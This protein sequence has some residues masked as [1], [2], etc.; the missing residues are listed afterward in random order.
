ML[1]RAGKAW[2]RGAVA[3]SLTH[4]EGRTMKLPRRR[5][6][7][8]ATLTALSPLAVFTAGCGAEPFTLAARGPFPYRASV[9]PSLERVAIVVTITSRSGDDLLINPADFAARDAERRVF[10]ANAAATAADVDLVGREPE[11]RGTLPLPV[12][13]LRQDDVLTGFVVFDVPAGVRPVELIWRQTDADYA[14][15]LAT[16]R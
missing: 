15:R 7:L 16:A 5:G 1:R 2:L 11:T 3:R 6:M 9:N 8:L 10:T 13:T 4:R 14:V 12:V